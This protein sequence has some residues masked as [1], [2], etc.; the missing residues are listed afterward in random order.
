MGDEAARDGMFRH[1]NHL[2]E[3]KEATLAPDPLDK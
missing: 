1:D 3:G 2:K